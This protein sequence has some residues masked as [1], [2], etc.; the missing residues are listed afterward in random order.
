MFSNTNLQLIESSYSQLFPFSSTHLLPSP[1]EGLSLLTSNNRVLHSL[2]GRFDRFVVILHRCATLWEL[3]AS[4]ML[5]ARMWP[6]YRFC[7][8]LFNSALPP[9]WPTMF[10]IVYRRA[11]SLIS[12][13]SALSY[14]KTGICCATRLPLDLKRWIPH[15]IEGLHLLKHWLL[16]TWTH[17]WSAPGTW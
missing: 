7:P 6:A 2:A 9:I 17:E 4:R 11:C 1:T 8:F 16:L 12:S 15:T 5:F 13:R 14:T 3:P 10:T